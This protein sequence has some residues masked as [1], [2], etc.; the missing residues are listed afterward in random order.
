MIPSGS[1][2]FGSV[3]ASTRSSTCSLSRV[4][5]LAM[6]KPSVM[7]TSWMQTYRSLNKSRNSALLIKPSLSV[8]TCSNTAERCSGLKARSGRAQSSGTFS[9]KVTNSASVALPP[10][11]PGP[12]CAKRPSRESSALWQCSLSASTIILIMLATT[13]LLPPSWTRGAAASV[14][15]SSSDSRPCTCPEASCSSILATNLCSCS[16][17]VAFALARSTC[18]VLR[19]P[20]SLDSSAASIG[21]LLSLCRSKRNCRASL[22]LSDASLSAA[23][24][25]STIS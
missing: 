1:S 16:L 15:F 19:R 20:L 22:S 12:I 25:F 24:S 2:A 18:T 4:L 8:S 3:R 17:A 23:L 14:A 10:V 5:L 7:E 6:S 9:R 11:A 21:E 13:K